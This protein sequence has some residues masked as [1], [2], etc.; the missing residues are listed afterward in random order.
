[1]VRWCELADRNSYL[2]LL[3]LQMGTA[4]TLRIV[5]Q[6]TVHHDAK[7]EA[8]CHLMVQDWAATKGIRAAYI[9]PHCLDSNIQVQ[10][11]SVA[12]A[13]HFAPPPCQDL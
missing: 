7:S 10:S 13:A 1:M 8:A 6:Y 5:I 3:A 11:P 9:V 12:S 4:K 2:V